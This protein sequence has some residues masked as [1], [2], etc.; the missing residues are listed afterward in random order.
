VAAVPGWAACLAERGRVTQALLAIPDDGADELALAD[1]IC[2]ACV[3]G[4]DVDGAVISL[5]TGGVSRQTLWAT[6]RQ[7]EPLEELEELQF[8]LNEGACME[9]AVTGSP[10]LVP[11]CSNA[12]RQRACRS[13]PPSSPNRLRSGR[14]LRCHRSGERSMWGDLYR[15]TPGA[16]SAAQRRDAI[17]ASA[18]AALML[19]GPRTDPLPRWWRR[20][21]HI[22]AGPVIQRSSRGAPGHRRGHR[23][24]GASVP[25]WRWRGCAVMPFVEQRLIVD[26]ARD[27]VARVAVHRGKECAATRHHGMPLS[28][29]A[30]QVVETDHLANL[31]RQWR[32]RQI[33]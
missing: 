19:I 7:T 32:D 21:R 30:R 15:L 29:M 17:S 5:V 25:K 26:V 3:A 4:L 14:C 20:R 27:E 10:V 22:L 12:Q 24:A 33:P 6:A 9:A 11:T 16:L 8:T 18:T 31:G 23:P 28:D 1:Q 2:R 13:S